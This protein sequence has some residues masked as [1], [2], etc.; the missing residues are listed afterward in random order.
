MCYAAYRVQ[1]SC[2]PRI[3]T[4]G[5]EGN[6]DERDSAAPQRTSHA[7]LTPALNHS[8]PFVLIRG[9]IFFLKASAMH[10]GSLCER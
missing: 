4:D 9:S 3:D 1:E 6:T 5:H 10:V 2:Q 7:V 8:C